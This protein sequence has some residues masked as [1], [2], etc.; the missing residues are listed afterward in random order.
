MRNNCTLWKVFTNEFLKCEIERIGASYTY[1]WVLSFRKQF[2]S[3]GVPNNRNPAPLVNPGQCSCEMLWRVCDPNL[4]AQVHPNKHIQEKKRITFQTRTIIYNGDCPSLANIFIWVEQ[5]SLALSRLSVEGAKRLKYT[6][7]SKKQ[8]SL[9]LSDLFPL[10][11]SK[12]KE[13][14]RDWLNLTLFSRYPERWFCNGRNGRLFFY[15]EPC[16]NRLRGQV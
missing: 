6:R 2:R 8:R 1:S 4:R 11:S 16:S 10:D 7:W 5:R 9:V 12:N 3:L 13:N 14:N 15:F